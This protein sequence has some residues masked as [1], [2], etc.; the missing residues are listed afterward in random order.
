M[1]Q[2]KERNYNGAVVC[3]QKFTIGQ[4]VQFRDPSAVVGSEMHIPGSPACLGYFNRVDVKTVRD[5]RKYVTVTS[6]H[7]AEYPCSR[8][9]LLLR[10]IKR[11][12]DLDEVLL[13]NSEDAGNSLPFQSKNGRPYAL[14]CFSVFSVS[15][16]HP[17]THGNIKKQEGFYNG[18]AEELYG[19]LKKLRKEKDYDCQFAFLEL[20]GAEDLCL[21][22][23]SNQYQAISDA[24][25]MLQNFNFTSSSNDIFYQRCRVDNVHSILMMNRDNPD[26]LEKVDWNGAEAEM[27]FS[28]Q[29]AP[30]MLYLRNQEKKLRAF[31]VQTYQARNQAVSED[32]LR[33]QIRVES[34]SGEYDA[35]LRCPAWMLPIVL[36]LPD[37]GS[38]RGC[39]HPDNTTYQRKVYQS[40]TYIYP[41]GLNGKAVTGDTEAQDAD[42]DER[43]DDQIQGTPVEANEYK[44]FIKQ[45]M[46]RLKKAFEVE[47]AD[48]DFDFQ[49]LPVWRLLK[50]FWSFAS[51]PLS[52]DLREDLKYQFKVAINAIVREA[53]LLKEAR[54]WEVALSNET[55]N[56]EAELSDESYIQATFM[57]K[58]QQIV[59]ALDDSMQAASQQDRWYFGEQQSYIENVES[60]YKI[61]RC[62]YGMLKDMITLIYRIPRTSGTNQ[63]YIIP[64]LS[65]GVNPLIQSNAYD[66]YIDHHVD[67]SIPEGIEYERDAKIISIKLPYQALSNPLKYLG[68]LAHE[69]FHY[70]APADRANRNELMCRG[71]IRVA[72][73]E[74]VDILAKNC[75]VDDG[76]DVWALLFSNDKAFHGIIDIAVHNAFLNICEKT[77]VSQIRLRNIRRMV[78]DGALRFTV[79]R[80]SAPGYGCYFRIWASIRN[81]LLNKM[82]RDSSKI[83]EDLAVLPPL[84]EAYLPHYTR[85][86]ALDTNVSREMDQDE[87]ILELM[88]LYEMRIRKTS[89]YQTNEARNLL[90]TTYRAMVECPPD[91]FDLEVVMHG[92]TAD[93][94]I[95][96]FFWQ[97]YSAKRDLLTPKTIYRDD[98]SKPLLKND[99]RS[100]M[101]VS[102]YLHECYNQNDP[103][104]LEAVLEEWG[105]SSF[106]PSYGNARKEFVRVYELVYKRFRH[107]FQENMRICLQIAQRIREQN[108][109]YN[110]K[111]KLASFYQKYYEVLRVYQSSTGDKNAENARYDATFAITC[112]MIDAYQNQEHFAVNGSTSAV[113]KGSGNQ[114][115]VFTD[116]WPDRRFEC[117]Q[118]AYNS[119]DLLYKLNLAYDKMVV[120]GKLP[121]LWYRGQQQFDWRTLPNMMRLERMVKEEPSYE[122]FAQ[123]LFYEVQLAQ[124]H[125]LPNGEHLSDAEWIAFLQ[126]YEFKTNALDFSES[127][128]PA[129]YFA[130]E[131]WVDDQSKRPKTDAVIMAFNPVLFN[132]VMELFEVE[133]Q[134]EDLNTAREMAEKHNEDLGEIG[135]EL[136]NAKACLMEAKRA[137]A[138]A[139]QVVKLEKE[140]DRYHIALRELTRLKQMIG[141]G[142]TLMKLL[143]QKEDLLK[144]SVSRA[145]ENLK[146]YFETGIHYG[147][148]PL[149]TGATELVD[150]QYRYLYDP[151]QADEFDSCLHPRA[152]MVPRHCDRMDKQRGEF[153]YFNLTAEKAPADQTTQKDG[154]K[155]VY[156]YSR[157]SLEA[158]HE[159]YVERCRQELEEYEK[160]IGRPSKAAFVPFLCRIKINRYRH[161]GFKRYVHAMGMQ[162]FSVYPEYDKLA[163]DLAD[164]LNLK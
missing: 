33:S 64:M 153:V 77:P 88:K 106:K 70:A 78:W 142:Q 62:Y 99:I 2:G 157:W 20:L 51:F 12:E 41:F 86:F 24:I 95:R 44:V 36:G 63:P 10:R 9:Q 25:E 131:E 158:L 37:K 76:D 134:I 48:N 103:V 35:L 74:F 67:P 81:M 126:H 89:H 119:S 100:A 120:N 128:A 58:Y 19:G 42:E 144:K 54:N 97:Q 18:L 53:E 61:L 113:L 85:I 145:K 40:D 154:T 27:H 7:E 17:K 72:I 1:E 149:L 52:E 123:T 38:V 55:D 162:R 111:Q 92:K 90:R 39:F 59:N 21:I 6:K 31:L 133:E 150:T 34:C 161:S 127:L 83:V 8:K 22:V 155:R 136:K 109:E 122:G 102:Y 116:T 26:E 11:L 73:S 23:L 71:L 57:G 112:E 68:I 156:N 79:D 32:T 141:Q 151:K 125:I 75:Q 94:K 93:E 137:S 114:P 159:K 69:I 84:C 164:Q 45:A 107:L 4:N 121:M 146:R 115:P 91:I 139:E 56:R 152:V 87:Y 60:Y 43:I 82:Q 49:E 118:I 108:D 143:E 98:E 14:C 130:T 30:G 140:Y 135:N 16:E 50:E 96:Q 29:S 138:Q 5:F 129:L 15:G 110:L 66:S 47:D 101:V 124:A 148:P 13:I 80:T 65:F 132:L 104:M 3:F 147:Q 28:L 163:D 117:D 46:K 105:R 160:S